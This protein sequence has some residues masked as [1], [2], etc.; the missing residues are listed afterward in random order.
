MAMNDIADQNKHHKLVIVGLGLIGGSLAAAVKKFSHSSNASKSNDYETIGIV[1]KQE[2]ADY[3][4]KNNIVDRVFLSLED[5][6]NELTAGDIIF[7]A[8]P[9][10]SFEETLNHI[11]EKVSNDVTIT[12]GCSVKGSIVESVQKIY[13]EIPKQFVPGHPIAGSEQSGVTATNPDLYVNHRVILTPLAETDSNHLDT[14]ADL[15]SLC[16]ADVLRMP[17]EEHDIVLAATSHLPH[18]IAYSLV[19]TLANDAENENIFRYAAGGFRDFTRIASSDP[20]MWHDIMCTN[21]DAILE[22]IDLFQN[23]LSNLR[24]AIE[25]KDSKT[26]LTIF[27]RAKQARDDFSQL[28]EQPKSK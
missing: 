21:Q 15:W 17:V 2:T 11:K 24:Q 5:I 6:A 13:G 4:L 1:R 25:N 10:L 26:L 20:T 9:T 16:G 22:A 3:A 12:D 18:A 23:N 8:V 7:I 14:V 19:D 28:I 27:N